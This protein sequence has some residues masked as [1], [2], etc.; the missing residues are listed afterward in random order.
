MLLYPLSNF[1]S[2][3]VAVQELG[4]VHSTPSPPW[5]KVWVKNTLGVRGLRRDKWKN[6]AKTK[7]VAMSLG[8]EG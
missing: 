5:V 3:E 1:I 7:N 2:I 4:G 6:K 8:F